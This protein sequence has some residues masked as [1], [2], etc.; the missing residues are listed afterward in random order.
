MIDKPISLDWDPKGRLWIAETPEY[1]FRK[2][3]SRPPRDRISILED[4]HHDGRMDKRTVFYEGLDLVTS[5]VFYRDG[6]IVSQA[7]YIYW[8]RD[9]KGNGKADKKEILYSGFG[10][11]DTHAVV[12]NLRWGMDGW[13]YATVGYSKG[14]IYSGDGKTHFGRINDGVIRFRPDGSAMEQVCSK[15]GNTW[16][17]DMAPDGEIFFTQANGSHIDHVVM[18]EPVLARGRVGNTTSY[19]NIEDH[20]RSFPLMEWKQQAYV[21]IDWVGNFTAAAGCCIYDGGAWPEK[22]NYTHYVSE[23]TINIVHQ[24]ILKPNGVSYLASKDPE[25]LE[26]EFIASTDLWFRPIHQRVGPD[27]A[28]YILDFYNQ[29]VVHNDTRGPKHDPQGNAAIRPDR[30]HYFGR[31]WRVQHKEARKLDLPK[32]DSAKPSV[33]VKALEHPNEWVRMTA[34]RLLLERNKMDVVPQLEKLAGSDKASAYA[35]IHALWL[36]NDLHQ[37]SRNADQPVLVAAINSKD[38]AVCNNALEMADVPPISLVGPER[39]LREAILNRINDLNPRVRLEAIIALGRVGIL[40]QHDMRTLMGAY[41]GLKDPWLESA[42]VGAAAMNPQQ[43]I[44]AALDS[45]NTAAFTNLLAQLAGKIGDKQDVAEAAQLIILIASKPSS[46]DGLKEVVLE[47]LARELKPGTIPTWS[48][49]L[50]EAFRSLLSSSDANLANSSL[51]LAV[52]WDKTGSLANE[53]KSL[54]QQLTAKLNDA[55]QPDDQRAQLASSLLAVRSLNADILPSV[56]Q[57][58]G[59]SSSTPLQHRIIAVLGNLA[60]SRVGELLV[61]VYP[62]LQ[63]ELQDAA[64]NQLYKRPDWSLTLL[65]AIEARKINLGT[66]SPVAINRLRTHSD[67]SVAARANKIIDEIRGPEAKE[68][69][70]LIAK[71]TPIVVQPGDPVRGHQLFMKNCEVCHRFNGEEKTLLPI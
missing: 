6:V 10:T 34:L 53:V 37:L 19:L 62:K 8:L 27:G 1:P 2:D 4:T 15:G 32:L 29:A 50:H 23:P 54:V 38:S 64:L 48:T 18:P 35:R 47:A 70:A 3:R 33:L 57:I 58:L 59:S 56:A 60:E 16:G 25:R 14:D 42:F 9:T 45:N 67:K 52:R 28:L 63:P 40:D 30:D 13:I 43:F 39:K 65:D 5:M 41:P 17:V 20:R 26:K 36:L 44:A 22:Y 11:N 61:E 66:L 68:K 31:I 55:T 71:F 21:Q 24:D 12:S 51:P 7:P 69:D 49:E 46:M